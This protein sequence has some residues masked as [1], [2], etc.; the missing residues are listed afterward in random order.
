M[1][2]NKPMPLL[3]IEDDVAECIKFKDCSNNRADITFI[4]MTGSS[5]EGLKYVKTRL[6]EG[7]ILDLELH[8]GKGSGLQFL[9]DLKEANLKFRPI[10]IVTTNSS[11]NIVYNHVHNIGADLVFY[12]KQSD[13]S[14]EMVINTM[15]TLRKSL[16]TIQYNEL[17]G[18]LQTI[19]SPEKQKNRIIERINT[20]LDLVGIRVRYKGR[21]YLQESIY[22]L[23]TKDKGSSEAVLYKVAEGKKLSYSSVIRAIQTAINKAWD[24]SNIED[25]EK[26]YTARVNIKTGVPSPTEFI[27]YYADRIRKTI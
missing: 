25:L 16:H 13:Y 21:I 18:D 12:K 23:I 17:P 22:L 10:I 9:S 8:N 4:G 27:H 15:I 26:Y 1:D 20:E 19:E 14:H 7:I 2:E 6:P 11:S 24:S 3:L 5:I